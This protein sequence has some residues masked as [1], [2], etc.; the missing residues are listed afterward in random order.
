MLAYFL[1][2]NEDEKNDGLYFMNQAVK[3]GCYL[4]KIL[5]PKLV[6]KDTTPKLSKIK[7]TD[8]GNIAEVSTKSS[9]I[10]QKV[11]L[12]INSVKSAKMEQIRKWKE[13]G[14][15]VKQAEKNWDNKRI[16][17]NECGFFQFKRKKELADERLELFVIYDNLRKEWDA[18]QYPDDIYL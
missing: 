10:L 5:Y 4:A 13:K 11:Y 18:M 6:S 16:E 12:Y 9:S 17:R 3:N 1:A 8:D 2:D 14:K 15:E 7:L